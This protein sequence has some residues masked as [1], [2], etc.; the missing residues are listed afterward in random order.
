VIVD[1]VVHVRIAV[2]IHS[3]L[4]TRRDS[5]TSESLVLSWSAKDVSLAILNCV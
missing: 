4:V 3:P 1:D 2:A 5:G